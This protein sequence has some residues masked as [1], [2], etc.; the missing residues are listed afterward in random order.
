MVPWGQTQAACLIPVT[1]SESLY[2]SQD[3]WISG[4]HSVVPGAA[5]LTSAPVYLL[6]M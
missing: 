5:V 4:F 2:A 6:Q 3:L 1:I